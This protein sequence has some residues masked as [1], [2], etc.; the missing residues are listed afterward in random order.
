[1]NIKMNKFNPSFDY[2]SPVEACK[3]IL[4]CY[5]VQAREKQ[6]YLKIKINQNTQKIL[7]SLRG[8]KQRYQQILLNVI[9]NGIKFTYAGGV[10]VILNFIPKN[11]TSGCYECGELITSVVDSGIGMDQNFVSNLFKLFGNFKVGSSFG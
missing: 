6:L 3:E 8:D 11:S 1:M 10:I 9:Q 5:F 7:E 4:K 2:F